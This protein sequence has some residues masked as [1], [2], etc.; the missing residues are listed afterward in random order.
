VFID[1]K[2]MFGVDRFDTLLFFLLFAF[3]I[4]GVGGSGWAIYPAMYG[5]A[6]RLTALEAM[7]GQIFLAMLVARLVSM[8]GSSARRE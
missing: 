5:I 6:Q 1:R 7:M 3:L 8:Y 2:R 4:S